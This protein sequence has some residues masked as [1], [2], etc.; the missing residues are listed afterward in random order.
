MVS[1]PLNGYLYLAGCGGAYL[2]YQFEAEAG[3]LLWVWGQPGIQ[4]EFKLNLNN[5]G[6]LISKRQKQQKNIHTIL[7]LVL[8]YEPTGTTG[9]CNRGWS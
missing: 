9:T 6:N 5:E 3:G 2:Y 7:P 8:T 1:E 4:G